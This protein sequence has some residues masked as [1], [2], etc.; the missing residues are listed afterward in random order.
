MRFPTIV[1]QDSEKGLSTPPWVSFIF[2]YPAWLSTF[3]IQEG[4]V[5]ALK[6]ALV[7][8]ALLEQ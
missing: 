3:S 4:I 8:L 2:S 6:L 5:I 1:L 7:T